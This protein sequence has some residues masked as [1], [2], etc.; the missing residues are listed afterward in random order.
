MDNASPNSIMETDSLDKLIIFEHPAC[1]SSYA[2]DTQIY[3]ISDSRFMKPELYENVRQ[4][5]AV[6]LDNLMKAV[7]ART[8]FI[9]IGYNHLIAKAL[10]IHLQTYHSDGFDNWLVVSFFH[11][12]Q[13]TSL[14]PCPPGIDPL[15]EKAAIIFDMLD[16]YFIKKY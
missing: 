1:V 2:P 6:F 10:E 15:N 16:F 12:D 4:F 7:K 3:H 13:S 8:P 14:L 11:D 9:S 5:N